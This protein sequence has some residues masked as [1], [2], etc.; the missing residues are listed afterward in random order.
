VDKSGLGV[1]VRSG[2][3]LV[4]FVLAALVLPLLDLPVP[5]MLFG[6]KFRLMGDELV[7]KS[8]RGPLGGLP[9]LFRGG[10]GRG[11][12]GDEGEGNGDPLAAAAA[13]DVEGPANDL[14]VVVVVGE[15]M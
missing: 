11:G 2:I 14:D 15:G 8:G 9:M 4:I 3:F 12:K 10:P 13:F 1:L 7:G 5:G 6:G